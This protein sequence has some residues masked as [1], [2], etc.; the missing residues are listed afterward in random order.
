MRKYSTNIKTKLLFLNLKEKYKS[1]I[2]I[3]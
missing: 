1:A 2:N 3:I